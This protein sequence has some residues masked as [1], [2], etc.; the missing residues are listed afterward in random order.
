MA[1]VIAAAPKGHAKQLGVTVSS[2]D[3]LAETYCR[4]SKLSFDTGSPD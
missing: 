2:Y 3:E 4:A 1:Q